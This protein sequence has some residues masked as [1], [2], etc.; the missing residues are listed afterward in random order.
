MKPPF[1]L[2]AVLRT[3]E[4]HRNDE[5]ERLEDETPDTDANKYMPCLLAACSSGVPKV[6]T[7]ALDTVVKV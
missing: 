4:I 7:T 1:P 6:V 3:E 5:E 2:V